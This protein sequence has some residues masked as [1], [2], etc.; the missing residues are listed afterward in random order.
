MHFLLKLSSEFL[1]FAAGNY[2]PFRAKVEELAKKNSK[3]FKAW[4]PDG[5]RIYIP[6]EKKD[7]ELSEYDQEVVSF[8]KRNGYEVNYI[9]GIARKNGKEFRIGKLL[10]KI[11]DDIADNHTNPEKRKKAITYFNNLINQ[12]NNS[13]ARSASNNDNLVVV[14]SQDP[15]D[16]AQMSTGRGWKSCMTLDT[17]PEQEGG[18]RGLSYED[19]FQ[20]VKYGGLI[21]YLV[22]EDD[23]EIKRPLARVLIRR[24]VAEGE[25][26]NEINIAI[27]EKK[28]YGANMPGFLETVQNF[29]DQ[30]QGKI[31]PNFYEISGGDH[32][33][34]LTNFCKF[35]DLT[36]LSGEELFNEVRKIINNPT[37]ATDQELKQISNLFYTKS[38]LKSSDEDL[39]YSFDIL[40]DRFVVMMI[41]EKDHLQF[42]DLNDPRTVTL[43]V[44]GQ[45]YFNAK[46][47]YERMS[48]D[49]IDSIKNTLFYKE[50]I[51]IYS[52]ELQNKLSNVD[53][54]DLDSP[55]KYLQI[56]PKEKILEFAKDY[57]E[58]NVSEYRRLKFAEAFA[59][60]CF[61]R[62]ITD[63]Q[64]L[65]FFKKY[66]LFYWEN[67]S[68]FNKTRSSVLPWLIL[69]GSKASFL[70]PKLKQFRDEREKGPTIQK[71]FQFVINA[72][73]QNNTNTHD[74]YNLTN[75]IK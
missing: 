38:Y 51:K 5:D 59:H 28:V 1:R 7:P 48:K 31:N 34:T 55:I 26:Q 68:N 16:I 60:E 64:F 20:E 41:L 22:R 63:L 24:F 46:I 47:C 72:I 10:A 69:C 56:L 17:K 50:F 3:P 29:I 62:K 66:L 32:S 2:E 61:M 57:F 58:K 15:H 11:R 36:N 14:I 18:D 74:F 39:A 70:L 52:K 35:K 19:V 54:E 9:S 73:E 75:S 67:T 49:E 45:N 30:N 37:Y 13:D 43:M 42:L 65:F 71:I 6:L 40:F 23:K 27:S 33:D 4:F 21:A 12:F 8:L 53:V 44:R 25:N